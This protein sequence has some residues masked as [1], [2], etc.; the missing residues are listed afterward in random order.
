MEGLIRNYKLE[1][2]FY[3]CDLGQV[4][5]CFEAWSQALPRVAPFYAVKCHPNP[6]VLSTLAALGA[7]FDCASPGEIDL[8][9]S[10]GISPDRIIYANPCKRPSD[11]RFARKMGVKTAT[12]DTVSELDKVAMY[13]PELQMVLRIRADDPNA[14]CQ[15]GNKFGAESDI[16][17]ELLDAAKERGIDLVGVSFHV[18]SGASSGEAFGRAIAGARRVF[19]MAAERGYKLH[20]VDIGGG[21]TAHLGEDGH[22]FLGSMPD[23]VNAALE[24]HFPASGGYTVISEPGRYF[25]EK[26]CTMATQ[27]FGRRPRRFQD[28]GIEVRAAGLGDPSLPASSRART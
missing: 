16:W 24:E 28:G 4:T 14:R 26:S 7:G 17:V 27:I 8:V 2:N 12:F 15:L 23:A 6:G 22:V 18:G 9:C 21:F 3:V 10:L 19:D 5:R 11:L 13:Y 20:L 25:V 1:D